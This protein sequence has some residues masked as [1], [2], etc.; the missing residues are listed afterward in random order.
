VETLR[1]L[2]NNDPVKLAQHVL[3]DEKSLDS[4]LLGGWKWREGR[5]G[6]QKS[7]RDLVDI[8]NKVCII[9]FFEISRLIGF[10][11]LAK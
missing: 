3:V 8:L 2:L 7:L 5:Y 11:C 1:N 4:Y 9:L 10:S 6:V